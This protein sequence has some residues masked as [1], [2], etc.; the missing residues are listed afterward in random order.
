MH[1]FHIGGD[2]RDFLNT[3]ALQLNQ[4]NIE[5]QN[6]NLS[7]EQTMDVFHDA[8]LNIGMRFHS[9]VF[10][11]ILSGKN[12]VLD[13]TEPRKGKISGFLKDIGGDL[14]YKSRYFN[15][16]TLPDAGHAAIG[17]NNPDIFQEFSFNE[18]AVERK[19]E[20]YKTTLRTLA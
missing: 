19:L 13:Y 17:L 18:E 2:D 9:V 7:L 16:Q 15:L 6:R 8:S 11:T 4:Q 3:L 12:I 10:Q 5:V 20:I 1:Y 14:F